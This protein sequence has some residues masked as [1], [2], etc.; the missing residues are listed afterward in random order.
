MPGKGGLSRPGIRAL[1][2]IDLAAREA[3]TPRRRSAVTRKLLGLLFS[4]ILT[5]FGL[6]IVTFMIGRVIPIDP[7]VAIIGDRAT[8][9]VYERVR[10]ELG[11]DKPL[12][13]QYVTYLKKTLEGDFGRS[14]IS[15]RP[16]LEDL[17]RVFPATLELATTATLFGVLIGV[18]LGVF[19]AAQQGRILDHVVRVVGLAGYSV[20][21][22]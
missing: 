21:V 3:A 22:F 2:T 14:V 16:V 7:V 20:P 11:L 18:P 17:V 6:T 4:V 8:P 12:V 9:Q 19:A 5:F 10:L 13:E 1:T 15:A